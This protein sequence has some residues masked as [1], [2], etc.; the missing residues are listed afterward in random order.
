MTPRVAFGA[1]PL[2]GGR[3]LGPAQP[4]P[5]CLWKGLPHSMGAV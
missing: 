2:Q 5:R 1:S 3:H 4:D